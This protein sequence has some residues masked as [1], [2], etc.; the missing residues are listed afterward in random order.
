MHREAAEQ[1]VN[2]L[3]PYRIGNDHR[4]KQRNHT[5]RN[6]GIAAN[7]VCRDFEVLQLWGSNLAVHLGQ[8][9]KA[10][11]RKDRMSE[12]DDDGDGRNLNPRNSG[13][14]SEIMLAKLEVRR[15]RG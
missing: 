4:G 6:D 15:S 14:P 13:K 11:H 10:T 1:I 8:G 7:N 9:F 5:G 2:V 3:R 12:S